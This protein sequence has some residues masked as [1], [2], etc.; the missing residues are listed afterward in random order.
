MQQRIHLARAQRADAFRHRL[1]GIDHNA[2]VTLPHGFRHAALRAQ[3]PHPDIAQRRQAPLTLGHEGK[4]R[5]NQIVRYDARVSRRAG[6]RAAEGHDQVIRLVVQR[7]F[8]R[9]LADLSEA[10]GVPRFFRGRAHQVSA[11]PDDFPGLGVMV[12]H[13]TAVGWYADNQRLFT[14]RPVCR[15]RED[16]QGKQDTEKRSRQ[17]SSAVRFFHVCPP[18]FPYL[19][20]NSST[21]TGREK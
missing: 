10:D 18:P 21:V 8:Q 4:G 20:S 5:L 14:L 11:D 19:A 12:K 3:H 16:G 15:R 1:I 13:R 6:D 17:L 7:L 9:R 2:G